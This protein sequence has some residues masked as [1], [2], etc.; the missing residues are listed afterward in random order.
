MDEKSGE[1]LSQAVLAERV[2]WCAD[3]VAGMVG[4]MIGERWN[5]VD[6]EV[7]ASGQDAGGRRL[8]SNA[9]MALRRLAWTAAAP[10]GVRVNDRVVRTAQEQAGR[11]LRSV[12]W[13]A[14]L[15]AGVLATWPADPRKRTPQEWE[16]VRTAIPGGEGLPSSVIKGRTRQAAAFLA[17]HGRLPVDVF[18]LEGIPRVPRMLLLAAC[19]RQQATTERSDTDLGRVLLRLQ[20]P[21]RPD[22]RGY[23]DWAWVAC[24][25]TLPPTV[26]A[27]AVLH[28]PTLRVTGRQV[29]ADV[30]YTHTVPKARRTGHTIGVGVDWGLNTLLTAGALRLHNNGQITALG[31]GGQFRAAGV[32]A[33]QH[34]LRRHSERLH[35]KADHYQRLVGGDQ[36]HDLAGKHAVLCDEIQYV[37]ARRANLNDALAWAAARWAMDQAIAAGATVIYLEDLRSME[38]RGMGRTLNTRLSQQV[39]GKIVD[40]MRHLAAE[41]GVAVVAVPARNTSKHCPQCL[42]P[43]QHRKAPDKPSVAGWK[44]ALCPN[45]DGCGWQGDRDHGAWRRIAARGLTHQDK[46]VTDETSGAMVIRTVVDKLEA[47][48][49]ITPTSRKDRSK[50]SPTRPHSSRPA[51]RRRRAPSPTRPHHGQAGKRP[52]GHAPTDRNRLPRAAHRHPGVN[53]ISTSTTGHRPRGAALGAGFHFHAHASPP[54][55]ETIRETQS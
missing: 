41:A 37:S 38:A 28:L 48:A 43:L 14:D 45:R 44:W 40:R 24:P 19:D 33:K 54:R 12:K 46:T 35:G 7:L 1:V 34:R 13:R 3:L 21:L 20:L 6:V 52:E 9:W 51:P 29:R 49:V 4:A 11:V 2:G 39:R 55:W 36:Q 8:P 47:S 31:A 10:G 32:L 30:A 16:Q 15:T 50:T 53:T 42:S 26:P 5:R 27:D 23:R 17:A 22:P 25:I 18:E